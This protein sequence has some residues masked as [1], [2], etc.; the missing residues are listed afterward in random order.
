MFAPSFFEHLSDRLELAVYDINAEHRDMGAT[1][2]IHARLGID[3]LRVRFGDNRQFVTLTN[4]DGT[5]TTVEL[6][7][8][9]SDIEIARALNIQKINNIT[10]PSETKMSITGLQSGAF[11]S[12]L[13][14]MKEEIAT[15]QTQGIADVKA[16]KDSATAE[17]KTT[18]S[19]VR[20]KIKSEVSDALQEFAEF[21]N[22]GPA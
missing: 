7:L 3:N 10:K 11:K 16:A 19:G 6:D 2:D 9:A 12:L 17:I 20:D 4:P 13:A 5:E 14:E 21:T 22:G 1:S 18:I 15:A 8:S